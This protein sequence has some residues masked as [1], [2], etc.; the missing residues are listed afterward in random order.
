MAA[1]M[2]AGVPLERLRLWGFLVV[3][4]ILN[5]GVWATHKNARPIWGNT[6]PAPSIHGLQ[7]F[8]LG[9]RQL[10]YRATGVMLQNLGNAGGSSQPLRSYDYDGLKDWFFLADSM[11]SRANFMPYLAAYYFGAVDDPARVR[12][13]IDYL[14]IVGNRPGTNKWAWLAHAVYLA[15]YVTKDLDRAYVLANKLAALAEMDPAVP[16]W[17]RQMPAFVLTAKGDKQ[18][19]YAIMLEILKSSAERMSPQEVNSMKHYIC[20]RILDSA[21]VRANPLC[22]D[23]K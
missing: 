1:A 23:L 22:Q 4:V 2:W 17:A 18:A 8:A 7:S 10:A 20:S 12:R 15:R 19:A 3:C 13:V 14:E 11:D 16:A 5:I 21:E 9:D 6:P